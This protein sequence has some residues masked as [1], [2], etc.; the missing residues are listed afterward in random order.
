MP[1]CCNVLQRVAACCSALQCV[2]VCCSACRK[3]LYVCLTWRI[4]MCDMIHSCDVS[5]SY[6]WH[7]SFPGVTRLIY[8]GVMMH[9]NVRHA[10]YNAGS[11][12]NSAHGRCSASLGVLQCVAV[13]CSILQSVSVCVAVGCS[14]Y[15]W[16]D[17][18]NAGSLRNSAQ[19]R[20]T[21]PMCQVL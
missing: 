19:G 15:M 20:C 9:L 12:K 6:V 10:S 8:M 7:D 3:A 17:S 11:P 5:H 13:F 18:Y 14:V 21:R 16:L 2:A 4:H 1:V